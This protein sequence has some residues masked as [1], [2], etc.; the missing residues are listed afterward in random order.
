MKNIF[1]QSPLNRRIAQLQCGQALIEFCIAAA[2]L[3]VPLFFM[4]GYVAKY[5]DMQS[6]TI[7]AARYAAWER[8]VYF[9]GAEW[10]CDYNADTHRSGG[11]PGDA[12][13]ACGT[14]WKSD[15]DIKDE[16][17][18]RFFSNSGSVLDGDQSQP[19]PLWYDHAGM[20][21]LAS[22]TQ[23]STTART[24]GGAN[25]VLDIL[26]N[27]IIGKVSQ[28]FTAEKAVDLDMQSLYGSTVTFTPSKT[29][30][31]TRIFGTG[32][33]LSELSEKNVL[34]ANGWS[35]NGRDF[36]AAQIQPYLPAAV[37]MNNGIFKAG[38]GLVT[39]V[40][41]QFFPEFKDLKLTAALD[42]AFADHVP[43]DRLSDGA[44]V[45]PPKVKTPK[46]P[47]SPPPDI[48]AALTTFNTNKNSIQA[49]INSCTADKKA[50]MV[51][52]YYEDMPPKVVTYPAEHKVHGGTWHGGENGNCNNYQ[53]SAYDSNV[54]VGSWPDYYCYIYTSK[55]DWTYW[56]T[57]KPTTIPGGE[58][59]RTKP[60]NGYT[61]KSD[62]DYSCNGDL[63]AR[64]AALMPGINNDPAVIA[65]RASCAAN[66]SDTGAATGCRDFE[67]TIAGLQSTATNLAAQRT[68]L[69]SP[70]NTC[71]CQAGSG[72]NCRGT[73]STYTCS[74]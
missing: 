73:I 21:V 39:T 6:A 67:T 65:I 8:T 43:G 36:V 25:K 68:N 52:N 35:T 23:N 32:N 14:A 16:I 55:D 62:N 66:Q 9:G 50:E 27:E 57:K 19:K 28:I 12:K 72:S 45:I 69:N 18:R 41:G 24:P 51:S 17:G 5:H 2:T 40:G 64:I 42:P 53:G 7:Q 49:K 71:S 38:W 10:A 56:V 13:W 58:Q 63:D 46:P 29:P 54:Y 1:Y 59:V 11:K 44:A 47:V 30:A 22:Y 15:A 26:F 60:A 61:P 4:I 70:L 31:I 37:L 34:V 74:P 48:Q 3:L 33:V 20:P